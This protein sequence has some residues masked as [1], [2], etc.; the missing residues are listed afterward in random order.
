[1]N[2]RNVQQFILGFILMI[3]LLGAQSTYASQFVDMHAFL[4]MP[5]EQQIEVIKEAQK[6]A[7]K[8]EEVQNSQ[9]SNGSEQVKRTQQYQTYLKN[10]VNIFINTSYAGPAKIN[11]DGDA[12]IYAG[13]LSIIRYGK[14]TH[15][16][17]LKKEL[18]SLKDKGLLAGKRKN[19][20]FILAQTIEAIENKDFSQCPG[21]HIVCAPH[22]FGYKDYEKKKPFCALANTNPFNASMDCS[23]QIEK[24]PTQEA[25][26]EVYKNIVKDI[27]RTQN[28]DKTAISSMLK[29]FYDVCACNNDQGLIHNPY[30][31]R[32]FQER[33]CYSWL[34]QTSLIMDAF[35]TKGIC[36]TNG[37]I[38]GNENLAQ[39]VNWMNQAD[40][41][42]DTILDDPKAAYLKNMSIKTPTR[43]ELALRGR[44][45]KEIGEWAEYRKQQL[46]D[47]QANKKCPIEIAPTPIVDPLEK[48]VCTITQDKKNKQLKVQLTLE[49]N[50]TLE[51]VS[52]ASFA[53]VDGFKFEKIDKT[54]AKDNSIT[55][56]YEG[57]IKKD[58]ELNFGFTYKKVQKSCSTT[59]KADGKKPSDGITYKITIKERESNNIEAIIIVDKVIRIEN[60]KE[61]DYTLKV[62]DIVKWSSIGKKD[63]EPKDPDA[64]DGD[65]A[66]MGN[67]PQDKDPDKKDDTS[68]EKVIKENDAEGVKVTKDKDG[69][70]VKATLIVESGKKA[71]SNIVDIAKISDSKDDAN[72]KKP[73]G[74]GPRFQQRKQA[75]PVRFSPSTM[76]RGNR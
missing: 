70:K 43:A 8:M 37:E 1:M 52:A 72:K 47:F 23:R 54:L 29:V 69:Y 38:K 56:K 58:T 10:L 27:F 28:A 68:T 46:K 6:M 57:E 4:G 53:D 49:E 66:G 19:L 41:N 34:K 36:I 5:I 3:P 50:Q 13:W 33:T 30:A 17:N 60:G 7:I 32:M 2:F 65:D 59:L 76:M 67:K 11:G 14:C 40:T 42:L 21:K 45:Q 24:L 9:F 31:K 26:D 39:F 15:P 44:A 61:E 12:C 71:I 16:K 25:K 62:K 20:E 75:R 22:L 51:S 64:Q 63:E 73:S 35:K 48:V 55:F 74:G 18:Y